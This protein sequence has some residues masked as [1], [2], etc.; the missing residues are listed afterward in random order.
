MGVQHPEN[1]DTASDAETQPDAR[2]RRRW[3]RVLLAL[4]LLLAA[5]VVAAPY[6]LSTAPAER[7]LAGAA[8][9]YLRGEVRIGGLS[10]NWFGPMTIDDVRVIDAD[11]RDVLVARRIT[12]DK[13]TLALAT[14]PMNFGR[15]ELEGPSVELYRDAEGRSSLEEA[16]SPAKPKPEREEPAP[17]PQPRG[18]VVLRDGY[19]RLVEPD[20]RTVELLDVAA[21]VDLQTLDAIEGTASLR[22]P[23]GGAVRTRYSLKDLVSDGRIIPAGAT[24]RLVIRTEEA[25]ELG[26]LMTEATR[27]EGLAGTLTLDANLAYADRVPSGRFDLRV[28][29]LE[30]ARRGTAAIAPVDVSLTGRGTYAEGAMAGRTRLD[31]EFGTLTSTFRYRP[32]KQPL[33]LTARRVLAAVLTGDPLRLPA[34]ELDANGRIDLPRLARAIPALLN[35]RRDVTVTGGTLTFDD[36]RVRGGE[37][38]SAAGRLAVEGLTATRAGEPLTWPAMDA[39]FDLRL[40]PGTGLAVRDTHVAADFARLDANG[41]PKDFRAAWQADL[42]RFRQRLGEVFDFGDVQLAGRTGGEVTLALTRPGT[43]NAGL[44]A[45][46]NDFAFRRRDRSLRIG[47]L[48]ANARG[49]LDTTDANDVKL[50]A[51]AFDIAADRD[52]ALRGTASYRP[53]PGAFDANVSVVRA[54]LAGLSRRAAS[55]GAEGLPELAGMLAGR[56]LASRADANAAT[57]AGGTLQLAGARV[58]GES[59]GQTPLRASFRGVRIG[60]ADGKLTIDQAELVGEP[61]TATVTNLAATLGEQFKLD[62]TVEVAADLART[63]RLAA[64]MDDANAP[65]PAIAGDLT[66]KGTARS[67]AK[68]VTLAGDGRVDGFV[69]GGGEQ[70]VRVDPLTFAQD[71]RIE[72]DAA[73]LH[74]NDVRMASDALTL[75]ASGTVREY[76]GKKVLDIRGHYRGQW[77]Q[78][79]AIAHQLAPASRKVALSGPTESD[80]RVTGPADRPTVTPVYR[81]VAGDAK[82]GWTGGEVYGFDIGQ[83]NL[84]LVLDAGRLEAKMTEMPAAGGTMRLGGTVDLTADPPR[85]R[86]PGRVVLLDKARIN[87]E[88]GRELLSRV[89]PLFGQV[90]SLSGLIRLETRDIDMPLGE[91]I[92]RGGSG[93]GRLDLSGVKLKPGGLAATLLR[94]GG[95]SESDMQQV[96]VGSVDFTIADGGI[97]YDNFTMTFARTL[98]LSFHGAVRFDDGLDLGVSVPVRSALLRRFGVSGPVD[99]YARLLE[100][101]RVDIPV[102]G[103]RLR[104]KLDLASVDV[105]PLIRRAAKG[106]LTDTAGGL[107]RDVLRGDDDQDGGDAD[108][109]APPRDP[110]KP[111]REDK[112]KPSPVEEIGGL[113]DRILGPRKYPRQLPT[114]R[115]A[116]DR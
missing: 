116:G 57:V 31:G 12:L 72:P 16:L 29:G 52:V 84:P 60:P 74:L 20:G 63:L 7:W 78:I 3:P 41:T 46:A 77:R 93:S 68:G 56:L 44:R 9:G 1:A 30:A 95:L 73:T 34:A 92:H 64:A 75:N 104:P 83:A 105:R 48:A 38:P 79:M 66:W 69:A 106:L 115:P 4:I 24:A 65:P 40:L 35:I 70:A 55:L 97:R 22:L 14:S 90:L 112:A 47:R 32:D 94:L 96:E 23:G 107:L 91:A 13:G 85:L 51:D 27:R 45:D 54:D 58:N 53:A 37:T 21:D 8:S 42:A 59:L 43:V 99:K 11:G 2:R 36:L 76:A 6:L 10:L 18:R 19:V 108:R 102:V 62:G 80:F 71:V 39:R 67:G 81:G 49:R 26:P 87:E 25:I 98:D 114:T 15:V 17:P 61:A 111:P 110:P 101:A 88:V 5:L 28:E 50:I 82:V 109:P 89:N 103:T 33:E 113:L 100:G 86:I